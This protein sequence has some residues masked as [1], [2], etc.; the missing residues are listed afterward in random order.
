[1]SLQSLVMNLSALRIRIV[2]TYLHC[3]KHSRGLE[4]SIDDKAD[5]KRQCEF[6]ICNALKVGL[7]VWREGGNITNTGRFSIRCGRPTHRML[8]NVVG[9]SNSSE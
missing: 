5:D 3:P 2:I 9:G 8:Y 4:P 6:F 1:M 7:L